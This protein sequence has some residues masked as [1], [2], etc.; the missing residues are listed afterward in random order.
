MSKRYRIAFSALFTLFFALAFSANAAP[1]AWKGAAAAIVITPEHPMLL[2]GYI[3]PKTASEKVNDVYAK[4]LALQDPS[5]G[6]AVI[7]T[8]DLQGYDYGFTA[9]IAKEAERR[10]HLPREA[11]LFNAAHNHSAPAIFPAEWQLLYGC[12]QEE[13]DTVT[14]YI[15]W[16]KER[17]LTII[18]EALTTMQPVNV[19]F[20]T[21]TPVPF[22]MSRRY[23][24]EKGIV[25]RSG[26]GTQYPGGPR[27]DISP[28]LKV[29]GTD[30]KVKAILFGYA[31]HPITLNGDKFCGDY[32]GFAQQYLQ[33]MY[34]GSVAMFM[35]GCGGQ[36]VPNARFQIEY[37][38]GHG[39]TLAD[40]VKTALEGAQTPVTG[41]IRCAYTETMLE[42]EPAPDR[43]TLE[44]QA[45]SNDDAVRRKAAFLLDKMNRN[46]KIQTSIPCPLQAMRF[47]KELLLIGLS[48]ETV[49]DYAVTLKSEN[50]TQFTWVAGYCNYVFAYLPT[51]QILRE[52]GYEA[53]DAIRYSPFSGPF[54]EDVETRVL[55]GTRDVVKKVSA[56]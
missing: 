33:E 42:F 28:V 6:R 36:L 19:S 44:A 26:P 31:C 5:G 37:A 54:K 18:G 55:T 47:G 30:G 9:E 48:G 11:L 53:G 52:G 45:K 38:M 8:S 29:T 40:A 27:D 1:P 2:E 46:E 10:Y 25:Y 16:T 39:R 4:A 12:S 32:P 21:A 3:P 17:F 20:S 22:A 14:A 43:T 50:L 51:W 15:R 41:P 56:K 13:A 23:P 24:T 35:Q 49:A 7:V 34:P